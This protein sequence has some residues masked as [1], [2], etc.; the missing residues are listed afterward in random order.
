MCIISKRPIAQKTIP[1]TYSSDPADN[2]SQISHRFIQ[3]AD[4]ELAAS[5]H[6]QASE[7][8][9]G[10]VAHYLKSIAIRRE[11][12][13]SGHRD[14]YTIIN[15]LAEEIANPQE[16]ATLFESADTLH[17]NFYTDFLTVPEVQD[18]IENAKRLL[19]ILEE[20]V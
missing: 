12:R 14:F 20:H 4:E 8:A 2:H 13:H 11:W 16:F 9:W 5:D 19:A 15:R 1:M 7:K 6:L 10:A 18:R 17:A 3:Q